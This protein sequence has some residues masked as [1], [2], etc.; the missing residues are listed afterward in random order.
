MADAV[1]L[2]K[3]H[4]LGQNDDI[5]AA[6]VT[7]EINLGIMILMSIIMAGHACKHGSIKVVWN[8]C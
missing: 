6:H 2:N 7:H 1:K 3:S 5:I 4:I 8:H